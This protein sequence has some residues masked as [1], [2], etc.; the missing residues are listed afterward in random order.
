MA[1][2][3]SAGFR[4]K[5]ILKLRKVLS[6]TTKRRTEKLLSIE[7]RFYHGP[8]A[9]NAELQTAGDIRFGVH[10][11]SNE[12]RCGNNLIVM[13]CSRNTAHSVAVKRKWVAR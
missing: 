11:M 12:I 2:I 1:A 5:V 8:Y 3:E 9:Q 13:D 6:A 4:L 7:Q 10:S